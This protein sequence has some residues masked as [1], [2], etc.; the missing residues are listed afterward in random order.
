M[1][2]L[3]AA[4][5][6]SVLNAI[7]RAT[8]YTGPATVYVSLHTADPGLTGANE[9]ANAGGSA[10]ARQAVAF[11]AAAGESTASTGVIDFTNMPASTITH[12]ALWDDVALSTIGH[13]VWSGVL[14]ANKTLQLGDTFRFAIGS[15]TAT[16]S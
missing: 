11:S 14:A 9:V 5:A 13:F 8:A 4:V 12:I 16:E 15:I 3:A 6:N 1:A 7:L 2:G 10:Y